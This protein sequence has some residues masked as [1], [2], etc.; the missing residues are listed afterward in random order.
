MAQK[1]QYFLGYLNDHKIQKKLGVPIKFATSI[2][3]VF[4][5]FNG[6]GFVVKVYPN[7]FTDEKLVIGDYPKT[8]ARHRL[9]S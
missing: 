6:K 1:S 8:R 3:D 5:E 2:Y 9:S 4:V 7:A